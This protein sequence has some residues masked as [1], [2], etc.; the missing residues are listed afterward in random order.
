MMGDIRH[1]TTIACDPEAA[2]RVVGQFGDLSWFPG[3]QIESV[4]G[5][6]RVIPFG[7]DRITERLVS[8]EDQ[9]RAIT[10]SIVESPWGIEKH[11]A[12]IT[13]TPE[14]DDQCRVLYTATVEPDEMTPVFDATYAGA[15]EALKAHLEG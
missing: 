15:L 12:S 6:D 13:V 7:E 10:Y 3:V 5:D 9:S 14:G 2:W 4:E 8:R 1:E 11:E